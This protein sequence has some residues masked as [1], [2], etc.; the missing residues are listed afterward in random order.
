MNALD[1]DRGEIARFVNAMF[2]HADEGTY[3]NLR[4]FTHNEGD[5]P[6]DCTP[7][8]L[9][10]SGLAQLVQVAFGRASRAAVDQKEPLVFCPPVCT[11]N[12]AARAREVDLA[13]GLALSVEIDANAQAG[14]ALLRG[15]VGPPTV[16]VASGG[17][18]TDQATG[19]VQ[20]KLHGHWRLSE[21]TRAAED[22]DRLKRAR[23]LAAAIGGGDATNVP[24][25][26]PIRWPGSV[27]R[28]GEPKLARI[29]ELNEDAEIDLGDALDL[30]AAAAAARGIETSL[31]K[32]VVGDEFGQT[33]G[34]GPLDDD[35]LAAC[36]EAVPNADKSWDRWNHL[37]LCFWAASGGSDAGFNAWDTWSRKS[38][39]Y[40]GGTA[41]RWDHYRHS[42]PNRLKPA[43]LVYLAW[44][45]DPTFTLPS[46]RR[47]QELGHEIAKAIIATAEANAE[48]HGPR[49]RQWSENI[50]PICW[51]EMT[52]RY[53]PTRRFVAKG[54][55][56]YGCVTSL[57]GMGG[58]GKS[59]LAQLLAT[60]VAAGRRWIG[61]ETERC[62]V[63]ALFCED[64]REELWRRQERINDTLGF[65][66]AQTTS[67]GTPAS[68]CATHRGGV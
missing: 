51:P 65:S 27:H 48:P 8:K 4:T 5:P 41:A 45:A 32:E 28:K 29:I 36:A 17:E 2:K 10:G 22:H 62:R 31:R 1:A 64:D 43:T 19:E 53:A 61:I 42:P 55:I 26:H 60:A 14:I 24:V 59:L 23:R 68:P 66:I 18:W 21:P 7:V 44:E 58:I 49:S 12:N 33:D 47:S 30:L 11:L 37:G 9:N 50:T 20:P 16:V 25:V 54:W 35:D 3:V 15:L 63:L 13:N 57:Y 40:D 6:V 46:A 52:G 67:L 34:D 38:A 56:P 39:K